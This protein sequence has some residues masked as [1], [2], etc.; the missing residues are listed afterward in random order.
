M[1]LP[2]SALSCPLTLLFN[3]SYNQ[4]KLPA[5]WK[6]AHVV[7][8]HKKGKKDDIENYRPISLT[9][10]VVKIFEKCI[11]DLLIDKC[12]SKITSKQHGFL[13]GRSYTTQMVDYKTHFP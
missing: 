9:S 1:H 12:N 4:G 3:I 13:P 11:R 5:D 6:T 8:I 2:A 10:L 7:P